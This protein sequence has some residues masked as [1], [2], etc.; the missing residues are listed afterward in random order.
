MILSEFSTVVD[1]FNLIPPVNDAI[2][3]VHDAKWQYWTFLM[4]LNW[5]F[6]PIQSKFPSFFLIWVNFSIISYWLLQTWICFIGIYIYLHK[7]REFLRLKWVWSWIFIVKLHSI[8]IS[9]KLLHLISLL[10]NF[11]NF[12]KIFW[13][14]YWIFDEFI[15][16][17]IKIFKFY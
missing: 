8:W 11:L 7:C 13:W 5:I 10:M 6:F 12:S 17:L 15:E 16:F 1:K 14:N 9:M 3:T 2:F 4:H